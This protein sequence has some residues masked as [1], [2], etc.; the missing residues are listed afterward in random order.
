MSIQAQMNNAAISMLPKTKA[1]IHTMSGERA[2]H[3]NYVIVQEICN[4]T[5]PLAK[6]NETEVAAFDQECLEYLYYLDS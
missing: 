6:M 3:H 5:P 4:L 1:Y 2:E